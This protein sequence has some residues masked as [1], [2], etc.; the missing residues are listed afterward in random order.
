LAGCSSGIEP[1]FAVSFV[2]NVLEGTRLIDVNP[3]FEKISEERGFGS[4][5]LMERISES[6][7]LKDFDEIPDDIREVFVTAHDIT[8]EDHIKMQAAFQD[9]IDNA[10]SKTVNFPHNATVEDVENVYRLAYETGCKGVTVYRD[11]SREE[12][13]LSVNE[14][15]IEEEKEAI[16]TDAHTGKLIPRER[17]DLIQGTTRVMQ[18]GCGGLYVTVNGD[19]NGMP[20]EVFNQ[21]GKAGGCAASQS[22]AIGRLV[23]LALRCNIAPEEITKQLKGISCHQPAWAK[24]GKISS[25]ADA[26]AKAVENFRLVESDCGG[27][28]KKGEVAMMIGACPDCGGAV[29]HEGGCAVCHDCGF[30][31]CG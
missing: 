5:D 28:G 9:Y 1:L 11:G 6:N 7:S 14:S 18:T 16:P 21:I 26:I 2:R 17:P 8:P 15:E 4:I 23:S 19:E 31:K 25:C 29:E 24:G 13:V 3:Y 20:F 12:Q 27:N 30:T 10:V 22:E